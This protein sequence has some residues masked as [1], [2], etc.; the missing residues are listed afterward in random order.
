MILSLLARSEE[1]GLGDFD[2]R[3]GQHRRLHFGGAPTEFHFCRHAVRG[4]IALGGG[5][6]FGRDDFAFEIFNGWKLEDFRHRQHP[7]HF[8]EALLGIDQIG[9]R[10]DLRL[11]SLRSNR[12][13]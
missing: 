9:Y 7:S 6:Q 13:R 3:I 1:P 5:H 4:K 2:D 12:G 10:D 8:A 11:R